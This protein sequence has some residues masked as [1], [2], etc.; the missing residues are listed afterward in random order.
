MGAGMF[1]T[2][3]TGPTC[4]RVLDRD[5]LHAQRGDSDPYLS[6]AQWSRRLIGLKVFMSLAAVGHT[7]PQP[8]VEHDC[9]PTMLLA[10]RDRG[11]WKI[12]HRHADTMIDLQLP[13]P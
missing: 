11:G 6:S 2:R 12:V 5:E 10:L 8:Q 1:F 7:A 9:G 4:A 3:H 13:R